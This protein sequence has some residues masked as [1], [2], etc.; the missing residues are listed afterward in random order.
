MFGV[1]G[2]LVVAVDDAPHMLYLLLLGIGGYGLDSEGV[3]AVD[4]LF[5]VVDLVAH[6]QFGL[7]FYHPFP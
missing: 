1:F 5:E 6:G 7:Q 4:G 2:D 3:L